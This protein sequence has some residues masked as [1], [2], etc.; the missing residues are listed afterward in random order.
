M[1]QIKFLAKRSD[2][3]KWV[4]G[5]YVPYIL[6]GLED[7]PQCL[8]FEENGRRYKIDKDTVCQ[9]T[10]LYDNEG[11]EIYE[12]DILVFGSLDDGDF[13]YCPYEVTK[14]NPAYE[15]KWFDGRYII[16]SCYDVDDEFCDSLCGIGPG[17]V[18]G[19]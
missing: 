6:E 17:S 1:R 7:M 4:Y 9:F 12:G 14:D 13:G 15:V 3:D 2:Y 19:S 10:G 8:I 5:Y 18:G 11:K 16:R